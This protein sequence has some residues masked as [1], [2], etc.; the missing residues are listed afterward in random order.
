MARGKV[1]LL[2]SLLC[3][4]GIV[5]IYIAIMVIVPWVGKVS[6]GF[7]ILPFGEFRMRLFV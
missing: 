5:P 6:D 4:V 2:V 7:L 3:R 1:P